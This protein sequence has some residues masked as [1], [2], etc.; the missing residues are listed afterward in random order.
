MEDSGTKPPGDPL[1][2]HDV[3]TFMIDQM[4]SI[5]WQKLGLQPDMATGRIERDLSQAKI[6]IDVV[7]HLSTF[8]EPKLEPEDKNRIHGLIRD[9]RLNFVQ[10]SQEHSS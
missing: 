1:D 9:L 8:I 3:I 6:A 7:T 2:V 4:A 5:A 10:K